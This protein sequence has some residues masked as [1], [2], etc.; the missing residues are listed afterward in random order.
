MQRLDTLPMGENYSSLLMYRGLNHIGNDGVVFPPRSKLSQA[1]LFNTLYI[2]RVCLY[3]PY[4]LP[5]IQS[6]LKL[7]EKMEPLLHGSYFP[8]ELYHPI[9][10]HFYKKYREQKGAPP[11]F[12]ADQCLSAMRVFLSIKQWD[13][14]YAFFTAEPRIFTICSR[15]TS[16]HIEEFRDTPT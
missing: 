1:E 6:F 16:E 12:L 4:L 9:F 8:H 3:N 14:I 7:Y 2:L 15:P 5:D 11:G 10:E 13:Y